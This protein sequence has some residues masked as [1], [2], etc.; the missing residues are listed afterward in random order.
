[1]HHGKGCRT[2]LRPLTSCLHG[3][4]YDAVRGA[5]GLLFTSS[6]NAGSAAGEEE[7]EGGGEIVKPLSWIELRVAQHLERNT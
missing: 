7:E 3:V 4:K 5:R 2:E 1:M 6:R